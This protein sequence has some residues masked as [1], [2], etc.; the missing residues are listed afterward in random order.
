MGMKILIITV[1]LEILEMVAIYQKL[2]DGL[3][4]KNLTR[5]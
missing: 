5:S 4:K 3:I 2:M 1:L